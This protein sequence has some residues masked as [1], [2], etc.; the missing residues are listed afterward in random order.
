MTVATRA[1]AATPAAAHAPVPVPEVVG[2]RSRANARDWIRL[3]RPQQWVKNSFALAPLLFSGR[4]L[5]PSA[6]LAAL[7]ALA[8]MCLLASAIYVGNDIVDADADRRHPL[9]RSRPIAAGLIAPRRAAWV[10]ALLLV[11]AC[12]LAARVGPGLLAVALAY[13]LLNVAYSFRLKRVVIIDVF[14]L[15]SFFILRLL[16]GATA[17]GVVPSVWLLLCGGLLA[18]YLGFAK[19]RHEL[20]LL[21]HDSSAHRAVLS[22]YSEALLD[23]ISVVLL[24]ATVISYVMYTRE[25]STAIAV[26]SDTLSYST[27]FVIYGVFRYL[28]LVHK[29]NGGSPTETLLTDRSLLLDVLAW[30]IYCG[31]VVYRPH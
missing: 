3:L 31:V 29:K 13:A 30:L 10:A 7:G 8:T 27:V 6:Q 5:Q 26:G 19:R 4:A 17:I 21:G 16:A 23:Q 11:S 9:K 18:L 28:Y 1:A 22:D 14:V 12:A 24:S 15:A 2:A 20:T 25:S